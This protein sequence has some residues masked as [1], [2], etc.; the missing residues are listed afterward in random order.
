MGQQESS[1]GYF[2]RLVSA[3]GLTW[4]TLTFYNLAMRVIGRLDLELVLIVIGVSFLAALISGG[5]A[6]AVIRN[7][8]VT[9][10]VVSQIMGMTIVA[11]EAAR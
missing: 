2:G 1:K 7:R 5:I 3:V 4:L 6:A 11:I 10:V 8:P 9:L